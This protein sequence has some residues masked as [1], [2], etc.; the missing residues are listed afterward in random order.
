MTAALRVDADERAARDAFRA[1]VRRFVEREIAPHVDAWDEA[2]T[3]PRAL[4]AEAAA[5][6]LL[7][8]GYPEA[9]G[10]TPA[11]ARLA[12]DRHR[13]G[14]ARR[15]RRPAGE[16]VLALDRP[17]ADRR[18]RQRGAAAAHRPRRAR[19]A[20]KIAA[21]AITEPGAGSDVAR[22][23]C[24][25]R[26]DGDALGHRRR[27]DLHHLGPARRLDHRRRAHRRPGRGRHLADRRAGRR[28]RPRRARRSPRWAGGAAT[29]RASLRR[30]PRPGRPP[31]RRGERGLSRDHGQLQRRA[32]ADGGRRPAPSPQVCYDEALAWA[33]Q[34]KTF[35]AAAGRAPGRS[36]TSWSTCGCAS[37]ARAPGSHALVERCDAGDADARMG[38]RALPAEEPRD[39]D[40][41]VLRRPGGADPR[42][43][44]ASCAAP[45]ASAS[46][47]R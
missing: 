33:R 39:A 20:A 41:A 15:Q 32:A 35:G 16:P 18:A 14:R 6:G 17:A 2:G 43:A 9:Y 37:S 13:R 29:P 4:Y 46:T 25:A 8:L 3:F 7:G 19:A 1:S 40:D 11:A 45:R 5:A 44:W 47:A 10:G 31:D 42:R 23:A 30:L 24:R 28:A 38:R 27:E 36:A 34:R 22:I 21:L 26:R 12:P